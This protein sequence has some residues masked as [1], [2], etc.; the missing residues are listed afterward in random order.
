MMFDR[1]EMIYQDVNTRGTKGFDAIVSA[2][3]SV[4]NCWTQLCYKRC[5]LLLV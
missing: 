1:T 3:Q 5:K 4:V 2:E